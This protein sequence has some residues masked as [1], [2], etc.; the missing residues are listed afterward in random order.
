[1]KIT[2]ARLEQIKIYLFTELV[3]PNLLPSDLLKREKEEIAE[4]KKSWQLSLDLS[5]DEK[6]II[7]EKQ[8]ECNE[9]QS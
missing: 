6:N 5:K 8:K 3:N 7:T 4:L 2:T 1:M 9:H